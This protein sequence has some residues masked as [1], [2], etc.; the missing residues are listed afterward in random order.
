MGFRH[1][2]LTMVHARHGGAGRQAHERIQRVAALWVPPVPSGGRLAR[3][4]ALVHQP[5]RVQRQLQQLVQVPAVK[6]SEVNCL[7]ENQVSA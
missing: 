6:G 4:H 7:S 5:R 3:L 1:E 2:S